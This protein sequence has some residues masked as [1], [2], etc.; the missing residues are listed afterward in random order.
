L[1]RSGT[2]PTDADR[3][4]N[5][6]ESQELP[7]ADGSQSILYTAHMIEHLPDP[8]LEPFFA[9]CARIL[10]P[11]GWLRLE[12]PDAEKVLNGYRSGDHAMFR[13]FCEQ[14]LKNLCE[15]RK[16]SPEFAELHVVMIGI[17]SCHLTDG[18]LTPVLASK[19]EVESRARSMG[20]EE[21]TRWCVSLQTPAQYASGGH[22]SAIFF[23]KLERLLK[24][25]GFSLVVEVGPSTTRIDE[26]DLLSIDRGGAARAPISIFVEARK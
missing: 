1:A 13:Y 5:L 3:V 22:I 2:F 21:F 19:D 14:N 17:L 6:R 10:R 8:V 7:F 26:L 16:L 12:A 9:E 4:V 24:A 18:A 15:D 25:V 23:S 20:P 11:G